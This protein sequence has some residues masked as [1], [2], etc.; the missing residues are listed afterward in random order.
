MVWLGIRTG[1]KWKQTTRG[2]F[3]HKETKYENP[4][5][6]VPIERIQINFLCVM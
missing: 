2:D 5:N 4:K 6:N 1:T 3:R